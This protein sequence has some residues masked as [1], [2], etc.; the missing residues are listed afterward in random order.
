MSIYGRLGESAILQRIAHSTG[1]MTVD[2][3]LAHDGTGPEPGMRTDDDDWDFAP[4]A[5]RLIR[6]TDGARDWAAL[7]DEPGTPPLEARLL[8]PITASSQQVLDKLAT[9]PRFGAVR[10]STGPRGWH[11]TADQSCGYFVGRS[12]VPESLDDVILQGPHFTVATPYA[13]QPNPT[14]TSNKDYTAWELR[15]R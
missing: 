15:G 7:I 13:Q 6:S 11:E 1:P 8:R 2:R 5:A 14:M 12:A 3:S 4:H 10:T 9:A